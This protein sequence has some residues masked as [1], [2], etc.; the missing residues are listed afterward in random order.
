MYCPWV[1]PDIV[2][3]RSRDRVIETPFIINFTDCSRERQHLRKSL[4]CGLDILGRKAKLLKTNE[5]SKTGPRKWERFDF[6][7]CVI[8]HHTIQ[9][10][11]GRGS[12][13]D[14]CFQVITCRIAGR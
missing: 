11:A 4:T 5:E 12:D 8:V 9:T 1:Y 6:T 13:E 2:K 10:Y 14:L 3:A 7:P